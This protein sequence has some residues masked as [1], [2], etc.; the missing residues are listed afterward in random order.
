MRRTGIV[1]GLV[2]VALAGVGCGG[3][4]GDG[5]KGS[6][7][8]GGDAATSVPKKTIAAS[9]YARDVPFYQAIAQGLE[10]QTKEYGWTL[11][12]TFSKP[13]PAEQIDAIHTLL[14]QQPD[15]LAMIPIDEAGLVPAAREAQ[16]Q[17]VPVIV[18]ADQLK[19]RSVETAFV[20]GDF[21]DWGRQKAEWTAKQLDGK[22]V[23]GLIHGIR[24]VT[25]TELQHQGV[26]EVFAKYPGIRVVD[27][28]YAGNFN[29]QLGLDATQNLLTANPDLDAI[30]FDNDDL[31]LGGARA[32][33]DRN[34]TGKILVVAADGLAAGLEGVK[35]GQ[36]DFTINQCA[37][38]QGR[39][40]IKVFRDLLVDKKDVPKDV[41]TKSFAVTKENVDQ[42][43]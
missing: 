19:D 32:I 3:G 30:I 9:L 2:I 33:A 25:F 14:A 8:T 20:G 15:G 12:L 18:V 27:G 11:K 23:V 37:V 43:C 16:N 21:V 22:G 29:A 17:K 34:K 24:G 36:I 31:A 5:D 41:I 1:A 10:E 26:K 39:M 38:E 28:P 4:S 7:T 35:N 42:T 40:A 13:D 6:Q